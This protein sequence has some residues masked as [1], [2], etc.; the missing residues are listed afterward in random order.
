MKKLSKEYRNLEKINKLWDEYTKT[1][2]ELEDT[3]EMINSDDQEIS[4]LAK[5]E[6]ETL[7]KNLDVIFSELKPRIN[8]FQRD[9]TDEADAIVEIRAEL[10]RLATFGNDLLRMY[11]RYSE[12]ND[13][14]L[15]ILSSSY[16]L[17]Q[18]HVIFI[19]EISEKGLFSKLKL[20]RVGTQSLQSQKQSLKGEFI[21][22]QQL[23]LYF[24]NLK[25]LIYK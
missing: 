3:K 4:E 1:S 25:K 11:T 7:S 6:N 23:L 16:K 19:L 14:K 22:L 5:L 12:N 17:I 21:H 18:Q 15:K 20:M 8:N 9:A 13:W 24:Q 2:S 10:Q